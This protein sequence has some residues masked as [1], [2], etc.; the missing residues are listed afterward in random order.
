MC[1]QILQGIS[2]RLALPRLQLPF[3]PPH[4][5]TLVPQ[6]DVALPNLHVNCSTAR[7][8]RSA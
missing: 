2:R 6:H 5:A 1:E 8:R 3:S 4:S 7:S